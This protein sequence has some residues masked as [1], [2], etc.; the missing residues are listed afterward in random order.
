[1]GICEYVF[2][3]ALDGDALRGIRNRGMAVD[4]A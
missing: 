4:T 3:P 2:M 1:M